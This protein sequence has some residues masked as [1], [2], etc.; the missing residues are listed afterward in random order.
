MS[1]CIR[2][3]LLSTSVLAADGDGTGH[4]IGGILGALL[5]EMHLVGH[6]LQMFF[7]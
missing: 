1:V 2:L 6:Y 5:E 3:L 7:L 4:K